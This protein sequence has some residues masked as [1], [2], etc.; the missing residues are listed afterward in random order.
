[1][2]TSCWRAPG[3][4]DAGAR[5]RDRVTVANGSPPRSPSTT[6]WPNTLP[7]SGANTGTPARSPTTSSWVTALGRWR[8]AATSIGVCPW[9]RSQ[10]ASL[11]ARVV[12]PDPWSP[13]SM[14]TVGGCLAKRMRARLAAEDADELLVDDLDDLLGRVERLAHLRAERP[15]ADGVGELLDDRQR[16]VGVEQREPDVADRLVDVGLREPPLGAKVPEGRGQAVGE[17]REHRTRLTVPGGPPRHGG[18]PGSRGTFRF[19]P[20]RFGGARVK[21]PAWGGKV[22]AT[23]SEA[24]TGVDDEAD[25]LR[26]AGRGQRQPVGAGEVEGVQRLPGIRGD[27]GGAHRDAG[28]RRAPPPARGAAPG[29]PGP[30]PRAPSRRCSRRARRG[31]AP[32]RGSRAGPDRRAAGACDRRRSRVASGP[33]SPW[34]AAGPA[35]GRCRVGSGTAPLGRLDVPLV[36]RRSRR[37]CAG[38]RCAPCGPRQ[39]AGRRCRRRGRRGPG[40]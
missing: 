20:Q 22:G 16:D 17:A 36:R 30:A 27:V 7:R 4:L 24:V 31:R 39:Q 35:L 6:S 10:R 37:R 28:C 40:R 26:D 8:S 14:M 11:P 38:S 32:G 1:M 5:H 13:A 15:L 2:T 33:R 3:V 25:R 23:G 29:G 34:R 9:S 12:L 19:A 21:V 18:A